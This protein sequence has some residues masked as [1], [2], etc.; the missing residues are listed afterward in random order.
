MQDLHGLVPKLKNINISYHTLDTSN[1][2]LSL[3]AAIIVTAVLAV[4]HQDLAIVASDALQNDF[5]SYILAIPFIFAYLTYRKRKMLRTVMPLETQGQ[6][7]VIR[8]SATIAGVLLSTTAILLY[9]H[10]SY[11]FTPLEYHMLTLPIF[12]AGLTLILFNAQTLRQLA[13]PLAFLTFLTPPPSEILRTL[14]AELSV[15]SSEASYGLI[16]LLSIPSR[17]MS[18]YG[19]PI[20]Q[21]TRPNGETID[22][23]VGIACSGIY[24]L[25]GFLVFAVFIAYVIR[26]KPWKKLALFLIGLSLVYVLNITRITAILLIGY[27]YGKDLAMQL[28]HLLGGWILIFVGTLLLLALS[29]KAFHTQIFSKRPRECPQCTQQTASNGNFCL[30][31]GKI[32]KPQPI[33]IRSVDVAK[34]AAVV[35]VAALLIYLQTPVFASTQGPAI[36]VIDTP[37]GQQ[38]ST[39]LLPTVEGYD[40]RFASRERDFE[41]IAKQDFSLIYYYAPF[42]LTKEVV[43]ATVEVA[44]SR[45]NLYS[46][47]TCIKVGEVYPFG[48]QDISQI[49][50]KDIQLIQNPPLFAR[51]FVFQYTATNTTQAVLYWFESGGF[52]VNATSQKKYIKISL[53]AYPEKQ[54]DLPAIENQ[55]VALG[56]AVAAYWQPIQ[57]WS[58]ISL[59]LSQKSIYI[60]A[61][62]TTALVATIGIYTFERRRQRKANAKAYHKLSTHN[63][64]IIDLITKTK[65]T[66]PP[67]LHAIA[68]ALKNQTT[69]PIEEE[70]LLQS[71]SQLEQTG[72]INTSIANVQDEPTHIWKANMTRGKK[73]KT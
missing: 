30:S 8:H 29:E 73:A 43:Y 65:K 12:A 68:N 34:I 37:T 59:F 40:L 32:I 5:T 42:D 50:L 72:I 56:T 3:K 55:A 48:H 44:S 38:V 19:N 33:R 22:F 60:T 10:G 64:E 28:F 24:S 49:E 13:F 70:K 18:E 16:R 21:I 62:T 51:Y 25:L 31:C 14:G 2:A 1:V 58:E 15:I 52:Q 47:E 66:A 54:E 23:A 27:N 35:G 7:K 71:L 53:I 36:T 63:Q 67:T 6:P 17:L 57:T 69:E 26:D 4:F 20:I 11:T 45:Q 41:A 46:W 61:A 9:W 39:N